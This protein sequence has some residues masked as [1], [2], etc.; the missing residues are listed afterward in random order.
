MKNAV[1]FERLSIA[2]TFH[3]LIPHL[4]PNDIEK[5]IYLDS[6]TIVNLDIREF[7][8]IELNEKVLAAFPEILNGGDT[9]DFPLCADGLVNP[10]NYFNS[11]VMILNLFQLR[12]N[13]N[14]L[15]DGVKFILN[16]SKY[17]WLDQD[18]LNY[19]F[20]NSMV[21]LQKKFN[22]MIRETHNNKEF[23]IERK[24]YHYVSQSLGL[25]MNNIFNNLWWK[26]FEKTPW[27]TKE[28]V[29]H[30]YEGVRQIYIQQ[31][32]LALNVSAIMSGKTRAFFV[33]SNSAEAIKQ[34]FHVKPEEEFIIAD[35]QDS[36]QNLTNAMR[37]SNGQKVFFI[38]VINFQ[39]LYNFLIQEGFAP[40]KD[41]VNAMEFLS[42][43]EGVP[44]N[45]YPLVK[46]L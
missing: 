22:T 9:K 11:G 30:L 35:T 38:F 27:F 21:K 19:C 20:S 29:G 31:K 6:D 24:I 45:S 17:L 15:M 3:L 39:P 43:A 44:L 5:I 23:L 13:Y 2:S 37:L 4:L 8:Q 18:I 14:H 40:G 46:L 36:V 1:L 26:Y 41:F 25:N 34:I 28:A 32:K 10:E 12:N 42:D 33:Q 16:N 7:W